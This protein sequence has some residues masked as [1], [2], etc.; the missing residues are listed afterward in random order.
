[1][2]LSPERENWFPYKTR[3]HAYVAGC[4]G[5]LTL[6]MAI[7]SIWMA[8][9]AHGDTGI[10][11]GLIAIWGTWP[12]LWFLFEHY[13]WFDNWGDHDAVKRFQEGQKLWAKL[14]AGVGAIL[15]VLLFKF[16]C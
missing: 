3:R 13:R 8:M 11:K 14:W 12:P 6:L 9:A 10:Q 1:M 5:G 16:K 2:T 7:A 15:A 4:A